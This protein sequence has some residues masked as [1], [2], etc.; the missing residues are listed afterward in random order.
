MDGPGGICGYRGIWYMLRI[1]YCLFVPWQEAKSLIRA[2]DPAGV[3]ERKRHSNFANTFSVK[4]FRVGIASKGGL[5]ER[6]LCA[7]LAFLQTRGFCGKNI[8]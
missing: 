7:R 2:I 8:F 6:N 4:V 3:E 1:K 5:R